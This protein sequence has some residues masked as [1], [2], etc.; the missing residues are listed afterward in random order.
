MGSICEHTFEV[1]DNK[2][3]GYS[4]VEYDLY[5]KLG[6]TIR[7]NLKTN[8]YEIIKIKTKEV[9]HRSKDIYEIVRIANEL[10]G[11]E[12]TKVECDFLCRRK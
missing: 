8:E 5:A 12:N 4:L 2:N 11:Q 10:E 3:P 7:K 1:E 6:L 9:Q